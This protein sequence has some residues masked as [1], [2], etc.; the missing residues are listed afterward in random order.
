[1]AKL[2]SLEIALKVLRS[3]FMYT[4]QRKDRDGV[5]REKSHIPP[6]KGKDAAYEAV[7]LLREENP[8]YEWRV[9]SKGESAL[10]MQGL[11]VGI[12][13]GRHGPKHA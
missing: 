2:P 3:N 13:L 9:L 10:Y 11:N 6:I 12:D 1:M 8:D 7:Q 4:I 5:W